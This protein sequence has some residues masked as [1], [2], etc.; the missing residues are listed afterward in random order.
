L[1][2]NDE[3]LLQAKTKFLE[4]KFDVEKRLNLVNHFSPVSMFQRV[5]RA[6]KGHITRDE[7]L[8]FLNENGFKSGKG[9]HPKDLNL[10]IKAKIDY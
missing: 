5:D 7:I 10:I 8:K 6:G 4:V 3:K 1:I 2:Q 9:Y